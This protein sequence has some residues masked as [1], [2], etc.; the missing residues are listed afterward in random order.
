MPPV[1]IP[2]SKWN[3][4][5]TAI[6]E[7]NYGYGINFYQ[8]MIDYITAKQQGES[9]KPPHLPWNNERGLEKYRFDKPIKAYSEHDLRKISRDVS[10]QAKKDLSSVSISKR[11]PFSVIATAAAANITKHIETE[12]VTVKTKRKRVEKEKLFKERQN[13]MLA[14]VEKQLAT[15]GSNAAIES[16]LRSNAKLYRGKSAKAI[17]HTLLEESKQ[18]VINE[19]KK[20]IQKK[21]FKLDNDWQEL[22]TLQHINRQNLDNVLPSEFKIRSI[23]TLCESSPKVCLVQI[24]TEIPNIN[25]EYVEK[26]NELKETIKQF[27]KLDMSILA[28]SR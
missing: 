13:K 12:S 19:N 22:K 15:L 5:P 17:A 23:Q 3:K 27:D 18:N 9:V 28:S 4:P 2:E 1:K 6:Y 20:G 11:S 21:N 10:E 8:P 7:D 14:D 26:L 24:E 25:I 16:E